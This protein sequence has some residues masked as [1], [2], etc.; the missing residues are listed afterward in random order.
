MASNGTKE[1]KEECVYLSRRKTGDKAFYV[2][3]PVGVVRNTAQFSRGLCFYYISLLKVLGYDAHFI[4]YLLKRNADLP[5]A[6]FLN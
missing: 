6:I 2:V 1:L 4:S 5:K 3:L